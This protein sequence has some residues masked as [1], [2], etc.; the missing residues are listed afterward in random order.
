MI[1]FRICIKLRIKIYV[2]LFNFFSCRNFFT[3]FRMDVTACFWSRIRS[4]R[5]KKLLGFSPSSI[6]LARQE[7]KNV[8]HPINL[9]KG[10]RGLTGSHRRY[11]NYIR[12]RVN[13]GMKEG[14]RFVGM[15]EP[16]YING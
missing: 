11:K 6:N 7:T 15:A 2:R 5:K 12:I 1:N 10:N 16:P 14:G 4:S 3:L 9:K 8:F 13:K